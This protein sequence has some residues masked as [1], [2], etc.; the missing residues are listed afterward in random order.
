MDKAVCLFLP[1]LSRLVS[2]W[3][4]RLTTELWDSP[5]MGEGVQGLNYTFRPC[6][7]DTK[8]SLTYPAIL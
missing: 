4:N 6:S 8:S 7:L 3:S 1:L 2:P 5:I